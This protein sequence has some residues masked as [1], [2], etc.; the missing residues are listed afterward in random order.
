[1]ERR[2]EFFLTEDEKNF[3]VV[4]GATEWVTVRK[5][6][7]L[8]LALSVP[9]GSAVLS[10]ELTI[11]AD[12]AMLCEFAFGGAGVSF[13]SEGPRRELLRTEGR[14]SLTI[15]LDELAGMTGRFEIRALSD[16]SIVR[17][18]IGRVDRLN[19]LCARTHHSR[20][21]DNEKTTFAAVYDHPI[22]NDRVQSGGRGVF[23]KPRGDRAVRATSDATLESLLAAPFAAVRDGENAYLYGNRVLTELIAL[24]PPNFSSRLSALY[25]D[26]PVRVLSLCSG[27]AGVE[28]G[29][30]ENAGIPVDI[31]LFDINDDLMGRAAAT[32]EGIATIS[33]V[34]GDVNGISSDQF[35]GTFDVVLCVSGLHHVVELE[36]VL[37]TVAELLDKG[38]EFWVV[39][40]QIGR[41]GNR[42]WPEAYAVG[43]ALFSSLPEVFRRNA[44]TGAIDAAL[45]T[46]DFSAATFEGIRSSEIEALLLGWFEPVHLFRRNCFLW[47]ILEQTYF[48]NYDLANEEHRRTILRLVAAEYNLWKNG[49][50]PTESH[51]VYRKR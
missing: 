49:G 5:A 21:V 39:G 35:W 11:G 16:V 18:V 29:I 22:Y 43:N 10:P 38:G 41:D 46:S 33:G 2:S 15:E 32:L 30:I 47:R 27:A 28:R 20:R 24:P 40:E 25:R 9:A 1:L 4:G 14:S 13:V 7:M 17:W 26:R 6:G 37:K 31:T 8:F 48:S 23:E 42:L 12:V 34:T 50:R 44:H 19:L 36:H 3:L 51:S 45:P